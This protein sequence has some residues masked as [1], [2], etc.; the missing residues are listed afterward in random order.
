M[1]A[2]S[3]FP[4]PVDLIQRILEFYDE[5]ANTLNE[6]GWK[7]VKTQFNFKIS[8][9][10]DRFKIHRSTPGETKIRVKNNKLKIFF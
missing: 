3:D 1:H 9:S 8:V 4:K 10:I 5:G 6:V 2:I 7:F